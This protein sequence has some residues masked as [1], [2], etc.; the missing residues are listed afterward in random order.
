MAEEESE[1][2]LEGFKKELK[3]LF[4]SSSSEEYGL[5][6][7]LYCVR[8]CKLVE[9]YSG[10]WQVPLPQLQVLQTALCSFV[11]ASACFPSDC[12]HVCYTLSS[13]ALSAFELLLFLNRNKILQDPLKKILDSFQECFSQLERHQNIHL[14]QVG[15]IIREKGPWTN[16]ILQA[17]LKDSQLP[18][19]EVDRYLGSEVP[20]FF[21]LRVRYL[22]SS[23]MFTE[24]V[25]LAK[26]CSQHPVA[27]RHLFF[28]QA[29]LTCLLKAS[30]PRHMHEEMSDIDGQDAVDIVCNT[31]SEESDETLLSLCTAFLSQQ[32]H[33]GDLYCMW[34]LVFIW[35]RLRLRV[36]P[37]KQAF[38]EE[39]HRLLLSATNIRSIFSFIRVILAE[40]GKDGLQFCVELCTHALQTNPCD[41]ATKSLIY[42]TVAYLLPNDLEV[43]RACALLVFFLERTVEAYKT[44]FLLYTHPDQEYHVEAGP[45]GNHIR[46]EILQTLK[47][48]LYFDPEFWNLLNLRTNCL[49]LMSEKKAA[50]ARMMMEDDGWVSNYC[51]TA[52]K[53]PCCSW[54]ANLSERVQPKHVETKPAQKHVQI[55]PFHQVTAPKR[56]FQKEEKNHVSTAPVAAK[57]VKAQRSEK[58]SVVESQRLPVNHVT[59]AKTE[60]LAEPPVVDEQPVIKRRGRKPGPRSSVKTTEPSAETTSVRRSFRQLD[61]AQE[62]LAGQVGHR[63]HRHMTRLSEKKP[64][65]RRGR[66]PRWLLEGTFQAENSAPRKGRRP[67]RKPPQQKTPVDKTNKTSRSGAAVKESTTKQKNAVTS[68]NKMAAARLTAPREQEGKRQKEIPATNHLPA[69][70]PA[71]DSKLEVSLPDNEVFGFFHED[72]LS[73]QGLVTLNCDKSKA[74]IQAQYR[75]K[76]R[77]GEVFLLSAQNAS[78]FIQQL[79]N[80]AQTREAEGV[81]LNTETCLLKATDVRPSLNP[82]CLPVPCD[83]SRVFYQTS[84]VEMEVEVSSQTVTATDMTFTPQGGA[85]EHIESPKNEDGF[86]TDA[87]QTCIP[88]VLSVN[89]IVPNNTRR[90]TNTYVTNVPREPTEVTNVPKKR[91]ASEVG[92]ILESSRKS[93]VT[94][95]LKEAMDI[96]N[97]GVDEAMVRDGGTGS[98]PGKETRELVVLTPFCWLANTSMDAFAREFEKFAKGPDSDVVAKQQSVTPQTTDGVSRKTLETTSSTVTPQTTDGVLSKVLCETLSTSPKVIPTA[99]TDPVVL[100]DTSKITKVTPQD[101]TDIQENMDTRHTQLDIKGTSQ[102]TEPEDIPMAAGSFPRLTDETRQLEHPLKGTV[103]TP[104]FPVDSTHDNDTEDPPQNTQDIRQLAEDTLKVTF[105]EVTPQATEDRTKATVDTPEAVDTLPQNMEEDSSEGIEGSREVTVDSQEVTV[106]SQEVTVDSQEVTVDSQ[107]VTVDSQEV[108]VDSQEVTVD[109]SEHIEDA[110]Q[111]QNT[112]DTLQFTVDAPMVSEEFTKDTRSATQ[113]NGDTPQLHEDTPVTEDTPRVPEETSQEPKD[114]S[115]VRRDTP[116]VSEDTL[117][118][119]VDTQKVPEDTPQDTQVNEDTSM[120]TEDTPQDRQYNS[121]VNPKVTES[122]HTPK[123]TPRVPEDTSQDSEDSSKVTENSPQKTQDTPKS[124]KDNPTV[125]GDIG[126]TPGDGTPQENENSPLAYRCSLCN[127]VFKGKR[128]I[129]HAMYHFRRDQCMFCR[130][131]FK[132]DLLAMM[133]LSQHIDKLKKGNLPPDIEEV[134]ENCKA[135]MSDTPGRSTQRGRRG[136]KRIPVNS[137]ESTPPDYRK[138]RST[139]RISSIN[140]SESTPPDR[141][142]LRST[143]PNLRSNP[144]RLSTDSQPSPDTKL[145]TE[146]S[147]GKQWTQGVSGQ[148][149][150]R[151]VQ[152]EGTEGDGDTQAEE[153]EKISRRQEEEH[154]ALEQRE[155]PVEIATSLAKTSTGEQ[156]GSCSSPLTKFLE[157]EEKPCSSPLTKFLEEEEKPCSPPLT[158]FL[159]EEE[160][161]CSSPL[162]KFLEEEEKPCS[163]PL[164]KFLEEEEKPCSSPLTKFLEE[165]EKPCSSPLTKFLEEEEKPCSSAKTMEDDTESQAVS[166]T[167][168]RLSV[169]P[170]ETSVQ[171]KETPGSCPV[172]GCTEIFTGKR[173]SLLGHIL[174]D[175][176]GDAKPLETTFRHG[177]GKCNICKKPVLTLQHYQHHI[178]WHKGIPR[179][180]CLHDGCKARFSAATEMRNHAKTHQPLLA[181][182][183]FPGCRERLACLP[184][185]NRHELEHYR[186]PK[187]GKDESVSSSLVT[188]T[189]SVNVI[190]PC[191]TGRNKLQKM[192]GVKR[193]W[194]LREKEGSATDLT[195]T[196]K[197]TRKYDLTKTLKKTQVGKKRHV[198]G[199]KDPRTT[200]PSTV[201]AKVTNT[202]RKLQV[203][204]KPC[205]GKKMDAPNTPVTTSNEKAEQASKKLT[206]I[207][208]GKKAWAVTGQNVSEDDYTPT[209]P[210]TSTTITATEK[211]TKKL[212]IINKLKKM[213]VI[214]KPNVSKEKDTQ[215]DPA[216]DTKVT[217]KL[218]ETQLVKKPSV[219]KDPRKMSSVSTDED[220]QPVPPNVTPKVT[221][222]LPVVTEKLK[223]TRVLKK[224]RVIKEPKRP[225]SEEPRK[226]SKKPV[227]S[228]TSG[229]E[230]HVNEV[231]EVLGSKDTEVVGSKSKEEDDK[232]LVET[233]DSTAS[234]VCDQKMV[235]GHLKDLPKESPKYQKSLK[236]STVS[237]S[238]KCDPR[239]H[240]PATPKPPTNTPKPPTNTPKPPTNTP[241]PP[242][243]TPKAPIKEEAKKS[244]FFGKINNRPY[245]RPP[246]TAYLDERYTTMPKRR[247]EMSWNPRFSPTRPDLVVEASG[248]TATP[249]VHRQRCAKC[250][251]SFDRG[252]ELQTHVSLKKCATLFGFDSDED[253]SS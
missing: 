59:T 183:C 197:V 58:T 188:N 229:P 235:N 27:G 85:V 113:N 6:S 73:R 159:E 207:H 121:L 239:N 168:D 253:S 244:T 225:V 114:T 162:T 248:T 179:H 182:C 145:A 149:G 202:L 24:A 185:L 21:E 22:L 174:D 78:L 196:V 91:T 148:K 119:H 89:V 224:Q 246:P 223:K 56:R 169:S 170:L 125:S 221:E 135:G 117:K 238:K 38:L 64:P 237:K 180:P 54:S 23:E 109:T 104:E 41:A 92:E 63:P 79:H 93:E 167:Q 245:I 228:K 226:T 251:L 11:Q 199:D 87:Q 250:F 72:Y 160:K 242:T 131:L 152:V 71:H 222:K 102:N 176:R 230:K 9:V 25:V 4:V 67:G 191:K 46:F 240:K 213:R 16:P 101:T 34:D 40:L 201:S 105:T 234:S 26:T 2:E 29:Y 200:D 96:A 144:D 28:R 80:Y 243:N 166:V 178:L 15:Q 133:H 130:M 175:H 60:K 68:Q 111:I 90:T 139:N 172:E 32:L 7:K 116:M 70:S 232:P 164:T 61:M 30:L 214:K 227:K 17:I 100:E 66:K 236:T 50:L 132:N 86:S 215:P 122:A 138:L 18:R 112:A 210:T 65:K 115:K 47:R 88:S 205:V 74:P 53:E 161:P 150:R 186:L 134:R 209:G 36:N 33:R 110:L 8:F 203:K 35:S 43:C 55:K 57:R 187:E 171:G 208:K 19:D 51:S 241:K 218:K 204:R 76:D 95:I 212:K 158:K 211:V 142:K 12:E 216:T 49:K 69:V 220:T 129:A 157:E 140:S 173:R 123:V 153:Q 233:S 5:Q 10:R 13:L 190:K 147:E 94:D 143:N 108:T 141:R 219:G 252:E 83:D 3:S 184:E 128:V 42:K 136:R 195:T 198:P 126:Q 193:R 31:E 189:T 106:D 48:G 194:P 1:F 118:V 156:G 137:T 14:L 82:S 77:L 99:V 155:E 45:I 249:S 165:E 44:V 84:A 120:V 37:S 81:T 177:N 206:M 103:G 231:T 39:S 247:K 124:T 127:K 98:V 192:Q 154:S 75:V 163:S 107:E 20:V 62:N 97:I 181:V 146:E 52:T 151:R 217:E